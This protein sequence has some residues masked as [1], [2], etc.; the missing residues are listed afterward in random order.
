VE[1][2]ASLLKEV[3]TK[4]KEDNPVTPAMRVTRL[5]DRMG[6]ALMGVPTGVREPWTLLLRYGPYRWGAALFNRSWLKS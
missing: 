2:L 1:A 4:M 6:W 5:L 3:G